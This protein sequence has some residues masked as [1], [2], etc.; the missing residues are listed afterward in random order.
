MATSA[1]EICNIA[2]VGYLGSH[3]ITTIG[4][5]GKPGQATALLYT[6]TRDALLRA[7]P[8]NFASK[9]VDLAQD[10]T[11]VEVYEYAYGYTLPTDCVKIIRTEH[12][13][14]GLEH[15]YRIEAKPGGGRLLLSNEDAVA[16]E[17]IS[18]TVAVGEYDALFVQILALQL[19]MAMCMWITDNAGIFERLEQRLKTMQPSAQSVDAQEGK[20]RDIVDNSGW[21]NARL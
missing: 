17:Y 8:W 6:P 1:E 5:P 10:G 12:E 20:P 19:A 16:I 14:L 15:D 4:E 13:Y 18:N 11:Y 7:H 21:I 9:H 2:L 3:A